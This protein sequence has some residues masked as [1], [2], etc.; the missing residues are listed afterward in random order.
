MRRSALALIAACTSPAPQAPSQPTGI[1][2]V[3]KA[4][5]RRAEDA[6]LA[7]K[8]DVARVEYERAVA[9]ATNAASRHFAHREYAETLETWGELDG[10]TAH[11]EAAVAAAPGDA[12]AWQH[13]GL[14]YHHAGDDRRARTALEKSKQLAPNSYY[15]RKALAALDLCAND[16][17]GALAEYREML[18]LDLSERMRADV[19]QAIDYLVKSPGPYACGPRAP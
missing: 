14:L 16:R 12:L 5:V 2:P 11:L 17:D 18:A 9:D 6:E 4:D 1:T 7:R 3:V 15:P 8:H 10:A 13:L 19:Q